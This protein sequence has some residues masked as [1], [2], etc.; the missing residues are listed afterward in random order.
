MVSDPDQG[1]KRS[2]TPRP[3][4]EF[5]HVGYPLIHH[6]CLKPGERDIGGIGPPRRAT[7]DLKNRQYA[8]M[9]DERPTDQSR[10]QKIR[11]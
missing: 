8:K 10:T 11:R 2:S 5:A 7:G 9:K 6:A 4:L 1:N 3:V